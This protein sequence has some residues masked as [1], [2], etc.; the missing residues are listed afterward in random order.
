MPNQKSTVFV[1]LV[2]SLSLISAGCGRSEPEPSGTRSAAAGG[3]EGVGRWKTWVLGSPAE[4]PV[5]PPPKDGSRAATQ[6]SRELAKQSTG[7]TVE[8][9]QQIRKW[10]T[11][12]ALRPWVELNLEL[13]AA[14]PKDPVNA[15]RAYGYTSAAIYDAVVAA[16][17]HKFRHNRAAPRRAG[18]LLEPS[19]GPSY[20]SEH[21]AIAGAATRVLAYLFPERP[22]VLYD[23][24]AEEAA[25]SRVAAGV[26]Y[27]SDVEAG[28]ALGRA[29][30]DKVI[31]RAKADGSDREW[32]GSRLEGPGL[33]APP[34]GS[35][36]RPTQPLGGT[37]KTWVMTSGNQFRAPPPPEFGSPKFVEEC[38]E[39]IRMNQNLTDE[40]KR[41]ATFWA[42]GEGT[43][44]PPGVW[45]EVM[46][47]YVSE[48]KLDTPRAARTFALLNIAQADAGSAAW[49]TK[50]TYWGPRPENAIRDL[51]LAPGWKPLLATPFFPAY[52]SGHSTYSGAAEKVMSFL[53][54]KDT[55]LFHQKA[56][57]AGISRLYGGIH[58]RSDNVE[59]LKMG[60]KIGDLVVEWAKQDGART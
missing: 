2:V 53:F 40:Q 3:N 8:V 27:P 33:W 31:A 57:E 32:D 52:V 13:V 41:M 51:G 4:V 17:H 22:A 39:L 47:A 36:A 10:N 43:S 24:M 25:D 14:R 21:A 30:A 56:E 46:L 54:P 34:P 15:S 16:W 1:S 28:L 42:G 60:R 11:D 45:N 9:R 38:R 5:A 7:P 12:P 48:H 23:T 29:V 44:L 58:F 19:P 20:P 55:K 18:A 35:T 59:G 26:N 37:W 6:D 50:F 49:D